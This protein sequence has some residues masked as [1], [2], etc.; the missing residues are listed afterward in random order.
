MTRPMLP[1]P[2][3]P[4]GHRRNGRPIYPIL[5]AS[6]EDDS[7]K[8]EGDGGTLG[9][10][11]SQEDLSRLLA[12]EK[13]QGGRAAV[14]K[15]LGELGF[16]NSEALT[17]FITA[18]RDAEQAALTEVERREQAAE[19]ML[20]TAETRE[21]Q[22]AARECAAIRRAALAGLGAAGDDLSDAILL[23]DRA[24]DDHPDADEDAVAAAAE[25]LKER[26]PELFGQTRETTP[27]APGGSPA[28]GPPSRG[29][30][31]PKPGAAG[32]EMARRRGFISSD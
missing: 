27:P 13:T 29:G 5:G 11:V 4:L 19:E 9:D 10:A 23:I 2:H 14:K 28:G 21:A 1:N 26:R 25:Q 8:R 22:A 32:L 17:E 18:K 31:P 6:P 30:L 12:R 16:D 3:V 7:N 24:L 20:R 15:L